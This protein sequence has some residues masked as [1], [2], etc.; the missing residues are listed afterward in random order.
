[1]QPSS[2][3]RAIARIS[4]LACAILIVK[5]APAAAQPAGDA[6][7]GPAEGLR[8]EI[9]E[10]TRVTDR[11][12][13]YVESVP[14]DEATYIRREYELAME[15]DNPARF[16]LVVRHRFYP[17]LRFHD[18]DRM[19]RASLSAAEQAQ[20]QDMA[21]HLVDA[22]SRFTDVAA[23]MNRYVNADL[24]RAQPILTRDVRRHM[25]ALFEE[26]RERTTSV[27]KCVIAGLGTATGEQAQGVA[28]A[29]PPGGV[30]QEPERTVTEQPR[31][32]TEQPSDITEPPRVGFAVPPRAVDAPPR[33]AGTEPPRRTAQPRN[34]DQAS[35][36]TTERV[37]RAL[38]R[39]AR[40]A[41]RAEH[42][43]A[44]RAEQRRVDR[45]QQ[46]RAAARERQSER[47]A[48]CRWLRREFVR[49]SRRL[50]RRARSWRPPGC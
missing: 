7:C 3:L 11:M 44:A 50:D 21:Q 40:R 19:L 15:Q 33:A 46:R 17:A 5:V 38:D 42:R 6:V 22:V 27:L 47:A 36:A 16:D 49:S 29:Q 43:R 24:D 31:G 4:V 20:G 2:A 48:E 12:A 1:M 9:V 30:S 41:A 39:Q 18:D 14:P 32:V 34:T 26:A 10:I 23:T 35:R 8:A 45:T 13:A 37:R 25:R 28:P